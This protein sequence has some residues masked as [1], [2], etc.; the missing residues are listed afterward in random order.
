MIKETHK[1][2]IMCWDTTG[3]MKTDC[4]KNT[5]GDARIL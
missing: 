2:G 5:W 4:F 3:E 1:E